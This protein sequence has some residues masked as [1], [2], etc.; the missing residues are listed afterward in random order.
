MTQSCKFEGVEMD[1]EMNFESTSLTDSAETLPKLS[2]L[3]LFNV[4]HL[5]LIHISC[6]THLS[7]VSLQFEEAMI[8]M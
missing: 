6:Q 2:M 8:T 5:D 1:L 3:K 7:L 4:S